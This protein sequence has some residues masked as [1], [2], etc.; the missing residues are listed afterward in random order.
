MTTELKDRFSLADEVEVPNVW[1]EAR[2]RATAPQAA[3]RLLSMP[4]RRARRLS[5]AAVA[6]AVFA[7]A[8][9]FAWDLADLERPP[10]PDRAPALD[11]ATELGH[12][13]T[14]LPAPPEVRQRA[15]TA[16]TGSQLLVWGGFVFDGNGD[17]T[18]TDDGF[19]FD[20]ASRSW[21]AM[22]P[23]PLSARSHVAS[24]WTGHELVVWGG[25]TGD[26]CIPSEMF[27]D[28]G[29][30]FDPATGRWRLLPAAPI[31]G[32]TP[33]SVWTGSELI[34]WG[35]R[36][37]TV[38]YNDGAAYDPSTDSWRR[39]AD[40]P[41]E[42]TDGSAVWT[43]DEMIVFGAALDGNNHA[44]TRTDI[45]AAYDPRS[46]SWRRIPDSTLS[47]QAVT[48][49]WP[50]G[51]EMIG[52]DYDQASAAYD[53]HAN[54]WRRLERVPNPFSEC[55]PESVVIPDFVLGEFCGR[56][57]IFSSA[58][59]RWRDIS[60]E[61]L[62]GWV[63]EP[64]P[65]GDAFL[66]MAQSLELSETA[67]RTFDTK[68]F[69]YV[70]PD[71][72]ART[73]VTSFV[74]QTRVVGDLVRMPVVFPDGTEATVVYPRSS[75]LASLGVQPAVSYLWRDDPP[76]RFPI[77][78]LHDPTA[79]LDP[80]V[81]GHGPARLINMS[82]GG[83]EVWRARGNDVER[84]FWLRYELPSWTVLV[85]VRDAL[86][87]AIEVNASLDLTETRSGFPV[88]RAIGPIALSYESGEGQGAM[89]QIGSTLDPSILLWLE[90]CSGPD[91]IAAS[92]EYG[93]M[94]LADGLVTANIYGK[95][96]D[97]QAVV[98]GLTVKGLTPPG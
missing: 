58:E 91:E 95:P 36:D 77:V 21:H 86:A 60:R 6:L 78:F 18:P 14:E 11:L 31:V 15:A 53:P 30:A 90:R 63:V 13:W 45:G 43:G 41:I 26:C 59:D 40:A 80:Y 34:V 19:V 69:A 62:N 64:V 42:I 97:V 68:M 17:E 10:S 94:C 72:S 46:D 87:S 79:S 8:V 3:P 57:V 35:S 70:P 32:R 61:D 96:A 56:T 7:A 92:G 4:P 50:G 48:A 75:E 89:L 5:V 24:A 81:E 23:G 20:A 28:D 73:G 9:T 82:E 22:P 93:S 1:A 12:G 67:G 47:P 27:L 33:F 25:H 85:S 65:A 51:G 84:R 55:R 52:W 38:R 98:E 39:I 54:V 76:P 71:P 66:V 44:D 74:P 29:A 88:A 16:W 49:A 83:I 37:R 2:R